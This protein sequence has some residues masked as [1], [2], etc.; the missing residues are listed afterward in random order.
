MHPND[1]LLQKT[2]DVLKELKI[3]LHFHPN[4]VNWKPINEGIEEV[5]KL[6][7]ADF[8]LKMRP[9]ERMKPVLDRIKASWASAPDLRLG[10]LLMSSAS[11]ANKD[12]FYIEDEE[13]AQI[14]EQ[15]IV[16]ANR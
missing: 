12:L 15:F 7:E 3:R 14:V 9:V 2:L 6:N 10:Q 11:L 8:E 16:E 4:E 5:Q 1:H 13:L